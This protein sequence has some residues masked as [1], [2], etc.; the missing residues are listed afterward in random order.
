VGKGVTTLLAG[1]GK[2]SKEKKKDEH[3]KSNSVYLEGKGP[4]F[5]QNTELSLFSV[6]S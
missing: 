2:V 1:Q 4:F 5:F 6:V 3:N